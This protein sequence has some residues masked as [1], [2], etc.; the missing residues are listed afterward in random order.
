M[1]L[2]S[3]RLPSPAWGY[4]SVCVVVEGHGPVVHWVAHAVVR[5][6][7]ADAALIILQTVRIRDKPWNGGQLWRPNLN[8]NGCIYVSEKQ[9][10]QQQT[11]LF[12]NNVYYSRLNVKNQ[13]VEE[14]SCQNVP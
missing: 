3:A 12:N 14:R 11:R 2:Y 5:L 8:R 13:Q 7:V 6:I 4:T 10:Q 1:Q 9:Q